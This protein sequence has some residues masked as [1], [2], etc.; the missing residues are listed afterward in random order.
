MAENKQTNLKRK[1][2]IADDSELNR[3]MLS[4]ILGDD[5]D[6]IYAE[7]GEETLNILSENLR[8]DMLLLDMNMP[9]LSGMHVLKAM[10]ERNWLEEIPVVIISAEND[11]NFMKNAYYLGATDYIV[12]PFNA[13][14]VQHRVKNTL[15]MYSQKKQL[16][17]MVESQVFRREKVNNMLITIFSHVVELENS[18]SG[19]H[20]L[21]MQM[22]TN[23]LLKK[24]VEISDAYPL[25][26]E[27]IALISSV[28]SLH[29]IG[30]IMVPNHILN[31]PG[32]LATEEHEQMKQHTV[33][34][35]EFLKN[36]PIDQS[37][38]LM[39]TAHEICRHHHER[40]DGSGYPDGLRG[41]EIPISAQVVALA[42]VYD[43]LTGERCYKKAYSHETA[44]EMIFGGE[45]GAFNPLLLQC[46][47]E[48]SN[49]LF[50]NLQ[51]NNGGYSVAQS[52][53]ALTYE[54][55]ENENLSSGE[56]YESLIEA[57]KKKKE[58]FA[59]HC[60]GI[61]FEYDA[62]LRRVQ[63]ICYYNEND[64]KIYLKSN[65]TQF[66]SDSDIELLD[67]KLQQTTKQHPTL[68]MTVLVPVNGNL[69]WHKLSMQTIWI[70]KNH[71][72]TGII[73][74]F[75][76]DIAQKR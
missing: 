2:L 67:E 17:Q 11:D 57:E 59:N 40:W 15:T 69:R 41:D 30:K 18:E 34:G 16:V 42:D 46:L 72:Y 44:L 63:Y 52:S 22:I 38:K 54:A 56:R 49:E 45:C 33:N 12:R 13:F 4:D 6:Y 32:K 47:R 20:A 23:M 36:I 28:S 14:L 25:S 3:E 66:L 51:M 55:L 76:E 7:N 1:I 48:I 68:E 5:Y 61:Q 62:V 8:V 35:D 50:I 71:S 39:V 37:E 73:G 19:S 26:E 31:K 75:T 64:E 65:A 29:D 53:Y 9:K 24:L 74:Q 70:A 58:F 60:R 43:A 27:D 21:H 10:R